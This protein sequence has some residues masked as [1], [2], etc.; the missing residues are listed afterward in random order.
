[1]ANDLHEALLDLVGLINRPQ[2]DAH[3]LRR[4]GVPLD[5]ALFP[6]L[7]R[8]GVRG[9]IGIVELAEQGGR[10]HSTVS[11]QVAKLEGRGLVA[12]RPGASDSRVRE[13]VVTSAGRR[14]VEAI[15][16]AR[17][18]MADEMLSQWS[19][20]DRRELTRLVRKLADDAKQYFQDSERA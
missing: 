11:R 4:A 6:L 19:A 14:I 5:R 8:I 15:G 10:D 2:P 16:E 18:R 9:P 7:V 1:M 12:R 13:V 17:Q 20:K 3:L